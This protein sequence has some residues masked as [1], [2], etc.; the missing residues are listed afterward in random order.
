MYGHK[1][2]KEN[3]P[4]NRSKLRKREGN[5]DKHTED[6]TVARAQIYKYEE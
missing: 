2:I 1:D 6:E 4:S 3:M 5:T